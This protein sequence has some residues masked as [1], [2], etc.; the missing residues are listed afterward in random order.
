MLI[1][2]RQGD[3]N[4]TKDCN[5]FTDTTTTANREPRQHKNWQSVTYKGKRYQLFGGVHVPLFICLN[6]PLKPRSTFQERSMVKVFGQ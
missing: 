4:P 5:G 6:H 3:G 2:V 1:H